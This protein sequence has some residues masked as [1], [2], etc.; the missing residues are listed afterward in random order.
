[1]TDLP[2]TRIARLTDNGLVVDERPFL[3]LGAEI[4]NSSSSSEVAIRSSFQRVAALGANT[5]LAPVT[6]QLLEPTEGEFDFTLVDTMIQ[7]AETCGLRLIPL[8][9]GAWKNATSSYVPDWVKQD[10]ERFPRSHTASSGAIEHLSPFARESRQADALAFG[11]LLRHLKTADERGTVIMVQVENEVGLLGDSRDRSPLADRAWSSPVPAEVVEAIARSPLMP[12]HAEWERAGSNR[13]GTWTELFGDNVGAHEVF[14]AWAYASHVESVAAAGRREHPL[15]LFVNA[16]LD[17]PLELDIP[18]A[19][20]A[21]AGGMQPGDYPSGGPIDRVHP[22]W[23]AAAP[24]VDLL[25]PDVYF[26][27]FDRICRAFSEASNGRLFIPEMRRSP[28]GVAQM[29]WAIGEHGAI[30]VSPFGVDSLAPGTTEERILA[31]AYA[32]L[33]GIDIAEARHANSPARAFWLTEDQP[34]ATIKIGEYCFDVK[35]GD[36]FGITPPSFPAYG[37]IVLPAAGGVTIAGRGFV[38]TPTRLD[39]RKAGILS[40][41]ELDPITG[42][43]AR[44]LNGDETGGGSLIQIPAVDAEPSSIWPIPSITTGTGL[45]HVDLYTY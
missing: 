21:L 8:W 18:E 40:V 37:L 42:E 28:R 29:F 44:I 17:S 15:P 10:A 19:Q 34:S 23:A 9:F 24:T 27:D 33:N 3:V 6:W 2:S 30:G 13:S 5:V 1:M 22:V 7:V 35:A 31:D 36:V 16:W 41:R 39:G 43:T 26:G 20:L 11:T 32:L 38:M 25:T 45:L 14:M 12:A 4:H